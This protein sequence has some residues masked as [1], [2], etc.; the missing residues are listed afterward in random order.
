VKQKD[1]HGM[2]PCPYSAQCLRL[3]DDLDSPYVSQ[4]F[5]EVFFTRN[6]DD[7]RQLEQLRLHVPDCPTCT[8]LVRNA[9]RIR[10]RQ[11]AALYNLLLENESRIP[12]TIPQIFAAIHQEQNGATPNSKRMHYYLQELVVSPDAQKHN[13]NSNHGNHNAVTGPLTSD[14][15]RWFLR[16][17]FSLATIAAVIFAG[18][19]FFSHMITTNIPAVPIS[20]DN[21]ADASQPGWNSAIISVSILPAGAT[22]RKLTTI[23]NYD[24]V[25][26]KRKQLL[27][28]FAADAVQLDG[29]QHEGQNLLYHYLTNGHMQ[30]QVLQTV[31]RNT[32][33]F[34]QQNGTDWNAGNA[35]WMDGRYVFIADGYN[36]V[37]EVDSQ[38]GSIIRHYTIPQ[39]VQ[40]A[41]YRSPYLYYVSGLPNQQGIWPALYRINT[42]I[43]NDPPHKI[44]MRSPSSTFWLSP[45]GTTIFYLNRGPDNSKGI[46]SV[47]TDGTDSRLLYGGYAI[48]IGYG[49]NN[50]VMFMQEVNKKFQ[51]VQL[52]AS[53]R[54]NET[55]M[56]DAAPG[57]TSLCDHPVLPGTPPIC[58]DDIALA[59]YGHKLILNAY[60]PGGTHKV[61][62]DDLTTKQSSPLLANLDG[63]T[64]I[65]LPGWDRM[66]V[67]GTGSSPLSVPKTGQSTAVGTTTIAHMDLAAI[68][69]LHDCYYTKQYA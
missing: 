50:A 6:I 8:A 38:T 29:I 45:D 33:Y 39:T 62:Y 48:P 3:L 32:G 5:E 63:K 26:R 9:R 21:I 51:V 30:Y 35:L 14:R 20:E 27:P 59:P 2:Q 37:A 68:P 18:I 13:G 52:G 57:A 11:R 22:V 28:S 69:I 43:S 54:Q 53:P 55:V 61:L 24:P 47:K 66:T 16:Y 42:T 46:Y 15:S 19:G 31:G 25:A 49:Q 67:S 1:L 23:Y 10:A 65:Q 60:Y 58:E 64:Q 34:Y 4:Q 7:E 44:S 12:S 56:A 36:G 17:A 41:F 40:L